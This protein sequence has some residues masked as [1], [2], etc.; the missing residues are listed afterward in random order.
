MRSGRKV[1]VDSSLER[2]SLGQKTESYDVSHLGWNFCCL[3]P[4]HVFIFVLDNF[5]LFY[6]RIT[7]IGFAFEGGG[8]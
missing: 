7:L 6:C 3:F 8:E 2:V 1:V 5:S 4:P